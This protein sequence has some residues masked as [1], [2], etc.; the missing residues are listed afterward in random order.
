MC[1]SDDT[2]QS[3]C[4]SVCLPDFRSMS[5]IHHPVLSCLPNDRRPA[6]PNVGT[7]AAWSDD[8]KRAWLGVAALSRTA[9]LRLERPEK[10][11]DEEKGTCSKNRAREDG[12]G[13]GGRVNLVDW[14]AWSF[15]EGRG[16][17]LQFLSMFSTSSNQQ[18]S[19]KD[20]AYGKILISLPKEWY[21]AYDCETV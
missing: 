3:R 14:H 10:G 18:G 2:A 7:E 16:G 20:T 15:G 17:W 13:A 21:N 9:R 12:S 4:I 19:W 5:E 1:I 8:L 11:Q 6:A